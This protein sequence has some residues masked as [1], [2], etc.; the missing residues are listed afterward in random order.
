[1]GGDCLTLYNVTT[2]DAFD[3]N[4]WMDLVPFSKDINVI[5]HALY[6][7]KDDQL[8]AFCDYCNHHCFEYLYDEKEDCFSYRDSTIPI[9]PDQQKKIKSEKKTHYYSD[10]VTTDLVSCCTCPP[11]TPPPMPYFSTCDKKN[12]HFKTPF[13][14]PDDHFPQWVTLGRLTICQKCHHSNNVNGIQT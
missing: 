13:L 7:R 6:W 1:M 14:L 12:I 10:D 4:K 2:G 3:S 9:S 5:A 8:Y 11:P